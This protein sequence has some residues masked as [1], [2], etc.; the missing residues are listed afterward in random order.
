MKKDSQ[1]DLNRFWWIT[2]VVPLCIILAGFL[3][4]GWYWGLMD[5]IGMSADNGPAVGRAI[6][7]IKGFAGSGRFLPVSCFHWAVFYKVFSQSPMAFFLFRWIEGI[8]ILGLWGLVVVEVTGRRWSAWLF[9]T[10]ALGFIRFYDGFFY[11]SVPEVPGIMLAAPAVLFFLR[12]VRPLLENNGPLKGKEAALS[13]LFLLLS[14]GA[15]EPFFI[16]TAACGLAALLFSFKRENGR[17]LAVLGAGLLAF[18]A[19]YA[20]IIKLFVVR[21]Y[22]AAYDP[23]NIGKLTGNIRAWLGHDL[24]CH[25]PWILIVVLLLILGG[26]PV[27]RNAYHRFALVLGALLYTGYAVVLLPWSVWGHYALPL[28]IFAALT[29]SLTTV[30]LLERTDG[31]WL[32]VI[33]GVVLGLNIFVSSAV[34]QWHRTYQRDTQNLAAWIAQNLIF[35]HDVKGGAVVRVNAYEPGYTIPAMVEKRYGKKYDTFLF[36]PGVRDVL[37]DQNT[38]Y[39]LW[40][41]TWGDQDLRRLGQGWTP[42]FISDDWVMFRKMY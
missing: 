34:A 19:A 25:A 22:S 8:L 38:R 7:M 27:L 16:V 20:L 5:D 11:L 39:F 10:A 30:H 3:L 1:T 35:E 4:G 28:G 23:A 21:A 31:K 33:F 37:G 24:P 14:T 32:R 18:S 26:R 29:I 6:E 36:T 42:V 12:A 41:T 13:I 40:G 9:M 2:A 15:K 17:P